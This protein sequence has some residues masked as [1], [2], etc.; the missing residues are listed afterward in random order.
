MKTIKTS[1]LKLSREVILE[2]DALMSESSC[3]LPEKLNESDLTADGSLRIKTGFELAL[4]YRGVI[5]ENPD[6]EIIYM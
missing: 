6:A 2:A 4:A 1:D 3:I 5:A